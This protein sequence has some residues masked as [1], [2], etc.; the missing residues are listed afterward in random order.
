MQTCSRANPL[1]IDGNTRF[2]LAIPQRKLFSHPVRFHPTVTPHCGLVL[3]PGPLLWETGTLSWHVLRLMMCLPVA[4]TEAPRGPPLASGCGTVSSLQQAPCLHLGLLG[5]ICCVLSHRT[6]LP[7]TSL[8]SCFRLVQISVSKSED[9]QVRQ[10]LIGV[11]VWNT[12]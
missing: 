2:V 1:L 11:F 9:D 10:L 4:H 5:S 6:T 12:A 3:D 7:S 8:R